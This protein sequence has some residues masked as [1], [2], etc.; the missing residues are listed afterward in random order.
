MQVFNIFF[1]IKSHHKSR[2]NWKLCYLLCIFYLIYFIFFFLTLNLKT[3]IKNCCL[4][5]KQQEMKEKQRT[6]I[7]IM[8]IR[9]SVKSVSKLTKGKIKNNNKQKQ[10]PPFKTVFFPHVQVISSGLFHWTALHIKDQT[11]ADRSFCY[12]WAK[13]GQAASQRD[14]W[15]KQSMQQL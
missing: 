12:G 10:Y 2:L 11:R 1:S 15:W 7:C 13:R 14:H 4:R 5:R 9:S 6:S 8:Y 3:Y